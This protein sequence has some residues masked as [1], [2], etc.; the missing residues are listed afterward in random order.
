MPH[1][2]F[3]WAY[4]HYTT[5]NCQY[6]RLLACLISRVITQHNHNQHKP[7]PKPA[8]HHAPALL[9]YVQY[10]ESSIVIMPVPVQS[11]ANTVH[12]AVSQTHHTPRLASSSFFFNTYPS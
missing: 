2:R 7:K 8:S 1:G 3:I 6:G 9:L 11:T 5:P 12:N 4:G 10:P